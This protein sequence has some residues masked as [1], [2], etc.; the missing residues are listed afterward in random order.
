MAVISASP[1]VYFPNTETSDLAE[2]LEGPFMDTTEKDLF[3]VFFSYNLV[4]SRI[5]GFEDKVQVWS[6]GWDVACNT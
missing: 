5:W 3:L 4:D 1:W 2:I 6:A